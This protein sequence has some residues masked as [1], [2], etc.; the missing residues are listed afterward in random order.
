MT[1]KI[2]AFGFFGAFI[3]AL[4]A[5]AFVPAIAAQSGSG[6]TQAEKIDKLAADLS[7]AIDALPNADAK[8]I[9]AQ[10]AL[11]VEQSGYDCLVIQGAIGAAKAKAKTPAAREALTSLSQTLSG[12]SPGTGA[13]GNPTS[14]PASFGPPPGFAV[15][16]G[17]DYTP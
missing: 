1:M 15:G 3:L 17:S 2:P 4:S 12:C 9:E 5:V 6:Q 7:A 10:A 8:T 11:V 16:G 14:F 13:G